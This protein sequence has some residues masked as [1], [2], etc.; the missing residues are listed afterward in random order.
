MKKSDKNEDLSFLS[1]MV[2]SLGEAEVK[3]EEAYRKKKPEQFKAVKEFILKLSN[4][5]EEAIK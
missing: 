3:L 2:I 5:I 4:K 1:Q